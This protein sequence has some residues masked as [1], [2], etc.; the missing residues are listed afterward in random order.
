M[1]SIRLFG[2][3]FNFASDD[4]TIPSLIDIILRLP[5]LVTFIIFR[6]KDE[7]P[8]STCP[9]SFYNGYFY[10]L[11][12]V[13]IAIT[14]SA[15]FI[16]FISTRGSPL[17]NIRPRR[18]MPLLIY[19]RL[20]LVLIDIGINIMGS[21]IIIRVFQMCA[22]ILRATIITTIVLSW[23]VAIALFII[24]AFFI[25]LTGFV[26]AEKKWEMRIR[27]IFCCGRGYGGQSSDIKNIVKTL[28]YLFDDERFDLVPSDVAA[29]LILLQQED[30]IEERSVNIIQNVPL[31]LLKEGLYYNTYA[32]SAFGWTIGFCCGCC[33]C[34]ASCCG[35]QDSVN[36]PCGNQ[37]NTLRYLLRRQNPIILYANFHG[38][39]HRA[40]FYIAADNEK[41]TII[42]S[43]RG[44]L[45]ATDVLTDINAVEDVL[46][47]ELFGSGYCH[48]GMHSAAKY[49]LDDISTRLNDIFTKYPD[50]KLIICGYSLGAGIASILSIQLKSKYPHLKC[51]GIAMPG[52]VLSEN[53]ALATRDFIYSYVV[54]A[55]M[56][57]RASMR[58]LEHLRDRIIDA[59]SK[60]NRNKIRLLTMTLAR[61]LIKRG[62]TFH[63]RNNRTQSLID[64]SVTNSIIPTDVNPSISQLVLTHH[65]GERVHLVLPGT[66]IHLYSTDR[67]G[68]FSRG[69]S[70]RA[71]ITTYDQFFQ[72]I[73][74]PRMWLDHFPASYST[75]LADIIENYEQI[76]QQI[77]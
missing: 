18:H 56:I 63:S 68:L 52:S 41:K 34:C 54:D 48:S 61:T 8:N 44:T 11:L 45:S 22:I 60:C 40:P 12:S 49:I 39:F 17:K 21:V 10:P 23:S 47:T 20:F 42:V 74:H 28:Q 5:L 25:D 65:S 77:A 31:E 73:V 55:D 32:Q 76:S 58:S 64:N 27:L 16:C 3:R 14:I 72:L 43:I 1:P 9:S 33:T 62:Q 15:V 70:Y 36:D 46:E 2:R 59:L 51:Y 37:Y 71:G 19:I 30:A 35:N 7:S 67:V 6:I 69:I 24:L 13:Y 29:G 75:A 4:L 57:G 26:S 38:A 50:Y 66:I 53:L